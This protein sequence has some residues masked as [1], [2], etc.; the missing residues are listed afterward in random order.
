MQRSS[1]AR[2]R[3]ALPAAACAAVVAGAA[4]A[5]AAAPPAAIAAFAPPA[6]PA[7]TGVGGGQTVASDPV[8]ALNLGK[9]RVTLESTQLAAVRAAVGAGTVVH[10]GNGSDALSFLCYTIADAEAPQRLWFTSSELAGG[11]KIDGIEAV[12]LPPGTSA[13]PECPAL[14]ADFQAPRFD[15]GLWLG[16]LTAEQKRA[17]GA[18]AQ[19]GGAWSAS[20]HDKRGT[21]D[22]LGSLVLDLRKGRVVGV[23]VAH[24]SQT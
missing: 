15:D 7:G 4:L 20:Y 17:Y 12:E 9:L 23:Y 8:R 11:G 3:P 13:A 14:P 5:A 21:L 18:V 24:A 22:V 19:H 10:Q 2:R 1:K 6:W 16:P